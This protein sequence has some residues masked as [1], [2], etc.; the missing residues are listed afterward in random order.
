MKTALIIALALLGCRS[1]IPRPTDIVSDN[2]SKTK[3]Y[4]QQFETKWKLPLLP[5]EFCR[6]SF[7][8]QGL[9]CFVLGNLTDATTDRILVLN[10]SSGIESWQL[11]LTGASSF[12][13]SKHALWYIRNDK[14]CSRDLQTGQVLLQLPI[15]PTDSRPV[16]HPSTECFILLLSTQFIHQNPDSNQGRIYRIQTNEL[17]LIASI[18]AHQLGSFT[19]DF[20]TI[21][22]YVKNS[23][24]LLLITSRSW[25]W[26]ASN[27]G[28]GH[29]FIFN[30]QKGQITHDFTNRL[31]YDDV[32][33]GALSKNQWYVTNGWDQ[34]ASVNLESMNIDIE[35]KTLPNQSSA[36]YHPLKQVGNRIFIHSGNLGILRI[37]DA[38]T[39]SM[40]KVV[41]DL[42]NDW[43]SAPFVHHEGRVFSSTGSYL[44]SIDTSDLTFELLRESKAINSFTGSFSGGLLSAPEDST[45]IV[46]RGNYIVGYT[47][48]QK[49][50]P[51]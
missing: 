6:T 11:H 35:S 3:D 23:D 30:L 51:S 42:G 28:R 43:F 31:D 27:Q 50:G 16:L 5:N 4:W 24:T 12:Q 45:L 33:K 15:P 49:K 44:I 19:P 25:N 48:T 22:A 34:F 32:G 38:K 36:F 17:N 41:N 47:R 18:S 7:T 1:E 2:T 20:H 10:T 39:G 26:G 21:D 46:T 37:L 14:V 13:I 29:V 9:A 40:L 8:H